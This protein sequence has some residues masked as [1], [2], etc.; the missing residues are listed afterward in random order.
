M[1]VT[2][3]PYEKIG[4]IS[5]II[6]DYIDQ[7]GSIQSYFTN[8]PNLEGFEKQIKEKEKSFNQKN[9]IILSQ[10]IDSQYK[11]L[12]IS[13]KN[14][15]K[16]HPFK[17]AKHIYSYYWTSIKLIHWSLIFFIQDI[18]YYKFSRRISRKISR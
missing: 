16:Y 17:R 13:E 6:L 1:K 18:F 2:Q 8:F 7:K 9:R 5:K 15:R 4:F 10:T 3:L 14:K 11:G 12:N